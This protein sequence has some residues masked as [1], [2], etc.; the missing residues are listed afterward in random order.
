MNHNLDE[1]ASRNRRRYQ[2]QQQDSVL[3]YDAN[4]KGSRSGTRG[5][6]KMKTLQ[7][8][9][10]GG[11]PGAMRHAAGKKLN[12]R[13][14]LL[15]FDKL[16]R[17]VINASQDTRRRMDEIAKLT[18]HSVFESISSSQN[19]DLLQSVAITTNVEKKSKRS[20]RSEMQS[21]E[22]KHY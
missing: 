18:Q 2:H 7:A 4:S 13:E 17:G 10:K 6:E 14:R 15:S 16:N 1:K 22:T 5:H 9:E 12:P 8:S 20:R 21:I 3:S 19:H 11:G